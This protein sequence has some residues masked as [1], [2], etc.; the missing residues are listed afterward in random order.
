MPNFCSNCGKPCQ[1]HW[2][3]CP[4]CG[5]TFYQQVTT[6]TD[7]RPSTTSMVV[8]PPEVQFDTLKKKRPWFTKKK[9]AVIIILSSIVL[10]GVLT[11]IIYLFTNY[12]IRNINYYV[13]YGNISKSYNCMI[14]RETYNYYDNLIHPSHGSNDWDV[15]ASVIASFCTP[16][17]PEILKI[18]Q[19]VKSQC[20]NQND[21]EEVVNA[22]LSFTQGIDYKSD[23]IDR[24]QYPLETLINKGD[25][26]DLSIFFGSLVESLGYEAVII[27]VLIFDGEWVGHAVVGIDLD[28]TPTHHASYP[29]SYY[30]DAAEDDN[31]YWVCETTA[32]GW[33]VGELPVDSSDFLI[34][35]YAFIE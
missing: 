2:N 27:C 16:E 29:P 34:Q 1:S 10:A 33:M 24:A 11:P 23:L 22:L 28:F 31:Q 20:T 18:A 12:K 21:E 7:Y 6:P 26:E 8:K 13:S 17:E 35:S 5:K 19:E 15:V 3:V 30:L 4:Y 9:I 25:C 14:P 32:Q